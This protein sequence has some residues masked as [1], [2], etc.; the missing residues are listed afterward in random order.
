LQELEN[1]LETVIVGMQDLKIQLVTITGTMTAL[2][3]RQ[4][5]SPK[6]N[7]AVSTPVVDRR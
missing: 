3:S 4:D 7:N 5:I 6:L 1:D 2:R